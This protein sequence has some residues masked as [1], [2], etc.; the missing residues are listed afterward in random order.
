MEG[1]AKLDTSFRKLWSSKTNSPE[2]MLY[3]FAIRE[4]SLK[5]LGAALDFIIFETFAVN[6][7]K[8]SLQFK[9][10]VLESAFGTSVPSAGSQQADC[11]HIRT[12]HARNACMDSLRSDPRN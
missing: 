6:D 11:A 2:R 5:H 3:T 1:F 12:P 7:R 10:A 8:Y 9:A 4:L